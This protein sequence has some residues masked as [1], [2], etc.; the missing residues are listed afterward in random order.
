M[1][2]QLWHNLGNRGAVPAR[3]VSW[4]VLE[5]RPDTYGPDRDRPIV[6]SPGESRQYAEW[7]APQALHRDASIAIVQLRYQYRDGNGDHTLVLRLAIGA[8]NASRNK[9]SP[10][11]GVVFA[12]LDGAPYPE[13]PV[14]PRLGVYVAI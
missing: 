9:G 1:P 11:V 3:D 13:I 2:P 6:I 8:P 14:D 7:R 5:S 10:T 12:T 4:Q